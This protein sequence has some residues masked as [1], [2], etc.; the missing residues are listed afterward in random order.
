MSL[1]PPKYLYLKAKEQEIKMVGLTSVLL[2][3][4]REHKPHLDRL[5]A[6]RDWP[7]DQWAQCWEQVADSLI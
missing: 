6:E 7:A 2:A 4:S 5:G 1:K 3:D